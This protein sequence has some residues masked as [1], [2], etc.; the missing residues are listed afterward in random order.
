MGTSQ[1]IDPSVKD[2]PKWGK[3]SNAITKASGSERISDD[4]LQ[5]IMRYFV[6][7]IGG[8]GAGHGRSS[9]FGRAGITRAQKFMSFISDIKREGLNE[10]AQQIGIRD[11]EAISINDFINHLLVYCSV[12]NSNLDDTAANAAVDELLKHILNEVESIDDIDRVFQESDND[13]QYEWLCYFFASYIMEFSEE[14]FSTRVFEKESNRVRIFHE[15]RDYVLRS[16]EDINAAEGLDNVDWRGE[17]GR[18]IIEQLQFEILEIW[19]QE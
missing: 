15:I 18:A 11:I 5:G 13:M 17:Q 2:N 10:I 16:L 3:L 7:A 4:Q 8:S 1:S 19:S 14:L 6:K 9:T 12:G